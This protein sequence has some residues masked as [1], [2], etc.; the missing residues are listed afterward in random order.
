MNGNP[1]FINMNWLT[2]CAFC[3]VLV[4]TSG[5]FPVTQD[6]HWQ[7]S[8]AISGTLVV[9][10]DHRNGNWDIY[11]YDFLESREFP[12]IEERNPQHSPDIYGTCVVWTDERGGNE[13]IYFIDLRVHQEVCITSDEASQ[14][15]PALSSQ[16]IVWQDQRNGNWDIYGYDR[17]ANREFQITSHPGNQTTPSVYETMVVWTDDRH[18]NEDIY[19][20]DLSTGTEFQITSDPHDQRNPSMYGDL[21][22]WEDNRNGNADIYAFNM[23]EKTEFH[24]SV[25]KSGQTNP[26]IS[27]DIVVWIDERHRHSDIYGATLDPLNEFRISR[28][29]LLAFSAARYDPAVY[30]RTVLWVTEQ[31]TH[32]TIT[33]YTVDKPPPMFLYLFLLAFFTIGGILI[34]CLLRGLRHHLVFWLGIGIFYGVGAG[35]LEEYVTDSGTL[36]LVGGTPL[37]SLFTALYTSRKAISS[38][39]VC[40]VVIT[41]GIIDALR[42]PCEASHVIMGLLVLVICVSVG[43]ICA[44]VFVKTQLVK[45]EHLKQRIK[46]QFCPRC[47]KKMKPGWNMCPYCK[48]DLDFTR[49]YDGDG[50]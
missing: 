8:P 28:D 14:K 43:I 24:I 9:W 37:L 26:V 2:L 20:Y 48:S 42:V 15:N 25:N 17:S 21:V 27:R 1:H 5:Y 22:V 36:F 29:P 33:G 39:T 44:H 41:A 49:V 34:F 19:G 3:M 32:S 12:I 30:E 38:L 10:E 40:S 13:D 18:G 47:G 46:P 35:F 6:D 7:W 16:V 31:K 4:G 50:N 45:P 11:G 23:R